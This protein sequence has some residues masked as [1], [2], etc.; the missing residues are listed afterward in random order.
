MQGPFANGR[1]R[2]GMVN[3]GSEIAACID[4]RENPARPGRKFINGEPDAIS[5]RS[6]NGDDVPSH[7]LN[8]NRRMSR[9]AM[10]AAR[11][12][13]NRGHHPA[14]PQLRGSP[15][16]RIEARRSPAIVI[17]QKKDRWVAAQ[18]SLPAFPSPTVSQPY[19]KQER[20]VR[21]VPRLD[22]SHV[23]KYDVS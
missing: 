4:P 20:D 15:P 14:G 9:H 2:A 23:A 5:R 7:R 17:G 1:D 19:R 18:G 12:A 8:G 6:S 13:S 3:I 21:G 10:S 22:Q 16:Q 11:V